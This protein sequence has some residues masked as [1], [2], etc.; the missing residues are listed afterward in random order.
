MKR[1]SSLF[2][3][4][5]DYENL[6]LAW[7]KAR[8]G[9]TSK[10][11]VQNFSRNVNK[12]LQVIHEGKGTRAAARY[13]FKCA[14]RFFLHRTTDVWLHLERKNMHFARQG[15]WNTFSPAIGRLQDERIAKCGTLRFLRKQKCPCGHVYLYRLQ[16]YR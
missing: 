10:K 1:T 3:Q 7:L 6:R 13:A 12:N 9:K 4:I 14:G 2:S 15:V 16:K 11:S 5:V 8:K